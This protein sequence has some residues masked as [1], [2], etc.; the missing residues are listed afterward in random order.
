MCMCARAPNIFF[1]FIMYLFS[2][3]LCMIKVRSWKC[4]NVR[5][6][7]LWNFETIIR[8][9]LCYFRKWCSFMFEW[10][11]VYVMQGNFA[12]SYGIPKQQTLH[13]AHCTFYWLFDSMGIKILFFSL[14][15]RG[16][17][18]QNFRTCGGETLTSEY[19][20]WRWR[21]QLRQKRSIL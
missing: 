15:S 7:K 18:L 16:Q 20:R 8:F 17:F 4:K 11:N 21:L 1:R 19:L 3:S 5:F 13:D 12:P 9:T 10:T 14:Q 2:Y 6:P